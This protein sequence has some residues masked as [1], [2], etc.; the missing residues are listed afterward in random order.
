MAESVA[1]LESLYNVEATFEYTS[2]R[3]LVRALRAFCD[4][5]FLDRSS[6]MLD[7]TVLVTRFPPQ[8]F[9]LESEDVDNPIPLKG[10]LLY[11]EDS[12]ILI[13]TMP[14]RPHERLSREIGHLWREKLRRMNCVGELADAGGTTTHLQN[15]R[16][17]PDGYWGPDAVDY[18]TCVLE[19][20]LSESLRQLDRDAQRWIENSL[21]HVT[22][23]VTVKIYPHRHEMI[24]AIWR[25]T[26]TR[27]AEKDEE[28]YVELVEGRPIVRNNRRRLRISFEKLFERPPTPGTAEGDLIFSARELGSLAR[29]VWRDM[30][31]IPRG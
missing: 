30:G 14:S 21:S 19:V 20:G 9:G 27:R 15:C 31:L 10:K 8:M 18:P 25:R 17:E 3:G 16:K 29:I 28:I 4:H 23:V 13:V 26:A 11:L 5:I 6:L 1:D 22:Q 24:F 12:H 2:R 7:H